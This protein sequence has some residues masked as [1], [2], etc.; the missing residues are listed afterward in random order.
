LTL[1]RKVQGR[2]AKYDY[3][4]GAV[5]W[6]DRLKRRE[7]RKIKKKGENPEKKSLNAGAN[8]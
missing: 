4:P 1:R 8:K 7:K 3:G 5:T 2:G 6:R